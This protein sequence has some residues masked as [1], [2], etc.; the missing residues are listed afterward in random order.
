MNIKIIDVDNI[1][2]N[3]LNKF[4]FNVFNQEKAQFLVNNGERFH[5]GNHNRFVIKLNNKIIGYFGII[6]S[7]V[8]YNGNTF[9]AIWWNDLII[10]KE[11]RGNNFHQ[12]IDN[13]IKLKKGLKLGFPN[14]NAS[15]IH[16]KNSWN[17]M[18]N[19]QIMA[20]PLKS[21]TTFSNSK[22]NIFQFL[23]I[24]WAPVLDRIIKLSNSYFLSIKTKRSKQIFDPNP[25]DFEEIF[26]NNI[27][28]NIITTSR[29]KNFFK[30]RYFNSPFKKD[31]QFY[32]TKGVSYNSHYCITRK[33][34]SD[35]GIKI[36]VLDLFGDF[37]D[38]QGLKDLISFVIKDSL[39]IGATQISI[40][41]TSSKLKKILN[42]CGFI[43]SRTARFCWIDDER[44]L[45]RNKKYN[46]YW[47]IGDSDNDEF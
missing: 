43:L 34:S 8:Y 38:I 13:F 42:R 19:F 26:K 39:R 46:F 28:K 21:Q 16:R 37:N 24:F 2:K 4:L 23:K 27:K 47:T 31:M 17:V 22:L 1:N 6:P 36:L 12:F 30:W 10:A 15:K 3:I 29:S 20:I 35:L 45:K 7:K 25:H 11:Y 9:E 32:I 41:C 44:I 40:L 33:L 18:Q 14:L 5:Q